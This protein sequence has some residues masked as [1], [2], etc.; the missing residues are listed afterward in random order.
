MSGKN[1]T[2]GRPKGARNVRAIVRD[3]AGEP[4]ASRDA[5][6][7]RQVP[8]VE[9]LL[10]KLQHLAMAGDIEAD[11]A[12]DRFRQH[13]DP[14]PA[15]KAGLLVVPQTLSQ[16]E[17]IR[18]ARIENALKSEPVMPPP[19]PPP[20]TPPPSEPRRPPPKFQPGIA[21]RNRLVR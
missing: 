18:R 21:P 4:V 17:W 6:G 7:E 5:G 15:A 1:K 10:R 11:K 3:L 16:E 14:E 20:P 12:L 19:A 9:A 2:R 8:V 13:V